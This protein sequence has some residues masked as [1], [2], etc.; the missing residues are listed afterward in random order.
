[1]DWVLVFHLL[2]ESSN[3]ASMQAYSNTVVNFTSET[4]CTNALN[5]MRAEFKTP[6]GNPT[7][8]TLRGV[9]LQRKDVR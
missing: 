2:T 5:A 9:C 6:E 8:I 1:M 4:L 7:R 3:A